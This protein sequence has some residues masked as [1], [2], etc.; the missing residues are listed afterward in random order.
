MVTTVAGVDVKM[1][2]AL[3]GFN[4][5]QL[6]KILIMMIMLIIIHSKKVEKY[7]YKLGIILG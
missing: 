4:L 6:K 5:F 1:V 3:F 2:F 7:L